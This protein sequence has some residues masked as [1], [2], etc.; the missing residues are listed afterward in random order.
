VSVAPGG[1][2]GGG[3]PRV[4]RRAAFLDRDGTLIEDRHYIA[5][6]EDVALVPGAAAAVRRLNEAGI[7]VVVVTNQSGI[8]RGLVTVAQY[9]GVRARLDELLAGEGARLDATYVC[10]HH[11]ELTG[12]CDCRKPGPALYERAA[13][14]H[15]LD[16]ARSAFV[17]DRWRD[18]E[19]ALRFGGVG[20]L[21]PSPDTPR[22][23]VER[24]SAAATV[25]HSLADAVDLVLAGR[26]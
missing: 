10:P 4:R 22:E 23:D 9:E 5:R 3:A 26:R 19:P 21:V 7:A 20:I 18:V 14:D 8:A 15:G 1:A 24:A 25:R 6:V 13:R 2:A 16:P 11:P 12:P 17:G